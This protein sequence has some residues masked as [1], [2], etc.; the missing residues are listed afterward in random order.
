M[1]T[2]RNAATLSVSRDQVVAALIVGAVVVLLGFASGIGVTA[3]SSTTT[4]N[5]LPVAPSTS[6]PA[7]STP[8]QGPVV[9]YV[10]VPAP[11]LSVAVPT[12]S[13]PPAT[14]SAA[15]AA[16]RTSAASAPP[17][18]AAP[19]P[20]AASVCPPDALAYLVG[21]LGTSP[22]PASGGGLFEILGIL[23]PVAGGTGEPGG[24]GALAGLS[25][26]GLLATVSNLLSGMPVLGGLLGGL[27]GVTQPVPASAPAC[28]AALRTL[29]TAASTTR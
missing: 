15:P 29:I 28:A 1:T 12:V 25:P 3:A 5:V 16:A 8:T 10:A 11:V 14:S 2:S 9:S 7:L 27:L 19:R 20:V 23:G 21:Q 6:A 13:Q 17:S 26:S 18:G 24:L 4:T 22:A